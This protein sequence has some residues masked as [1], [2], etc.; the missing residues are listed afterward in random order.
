[1]KDLSDCTIIRKTACTSKCGVGDIEIEWKCP[2]KEPFTCTQKC[3]CQHCTGKMKLIYIHIDIY[4]YID[5]YSIIK[6][7][8][9]FQN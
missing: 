5:P 1:M 2:D 6:I 7:M 9:S 3:C 8:Y 4:I